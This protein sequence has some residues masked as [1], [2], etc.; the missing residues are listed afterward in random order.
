MSVI[1]AES[2][3]HTHADSQS[4]L[5]IPTLRRYQNTVSKPVEFRGLSLFHGYDAT[6][7]LIPAP[8]NT[9]IVFRRTDL[10]D[11]PDIP[12]TTDFLVREPRR[13]V[14]A[15]TPDCRIETTEH[16]MAALAGL[17]IDNVIVEVT[18]PELPAYDGSCRAFCDGILDAGIEGQ[19]HGAAIVQVDDVYTVRSSNRKQTLTVR[20]YL[21]PCT[22]ITYHFDY[23]VRSL[24]PPQQ[25]SVE[26]TPA[27]FYHEISPARTFVLESEVSALKKLGYGK[28]LTTKD[29][30]VIGQDGPIDNPLRWS[31]EGVR[32][33][34]LD[35]VGDLA[36]NGSGF[37]GHV[38]ASRSGHEL[39]HEMAKVLSMM[40]KSN[41][42]LS[43][44]A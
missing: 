18:C 42:L 8:A 17:Q 5:R 44:A 3:Q 10:V 22:A 7:R 38:T 35:C 11:R 28:H 39:N 14:L 25:L 6:A 13:T 1:E 29:L 32:H 41:S 2:S 4:T 43:K 21:F 16:L 12:A 36:L 33:K 9:G 15:S 34:I 40:G 19:D 30:V 20:P 31:D 37:Y 26:I 23:G 24:V 27:F